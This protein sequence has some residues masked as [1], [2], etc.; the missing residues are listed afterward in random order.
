MTPKLTIRSFTNDQYCLDKV[1]YSNFYRMKGFKEVDKKPVVMDIGAHCG[2]FTFAA[3]SLGAKKVY[4]FEPFAPNYN[5]L[6]ANV[7]YNPMGSPF[8]VITQQLG[9]YVAPIAL[10]FG[11]PELLNQS[12]F[13]YANVGMDTNPTSAEF[14]KCCMLTLDT[15]LEHYVGEQ[16]DIMKL[17]I[18]Y[19]EMVII[20]SSTLIKDRVHNLCGEIALDD[21]GIAKFKSILGVKGFIDTQLFPVEGEEGKWLF[22]SSK[23]D[24]KEAFN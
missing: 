1:F 18:G 4:A 9:V 14:C 13:D 6:M 19:A 21:A 23:K 7:G 10:T 22:H 24:R 15:L 16:V 2:Y 20:E 3:L 11:Y 5:I 17:S 8:A 12:Y